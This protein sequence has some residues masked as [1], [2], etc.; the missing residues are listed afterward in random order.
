MGRGQRIKVL[1]SV[2][3]LDGHSTGAEVVSR[4]L[5]DSGMEVVYLG[6]YQTPE[7]VV[8]AAIQEDV[9][10]IGISSHASNYGQI[11]ELMGLLREK[12]LEDICVICGGTIPKKQIKELKEK[13]VSEVFAPQ[14]T[15][16]AIVNYII[17]NAKRYK[18]SS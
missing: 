10:V 16:E 12:K 6:I 8:Q 7:M 17:S 11:V 14:S 5:M 13:G 15:S 18:V 2:I 9:D 3:G 4:M 1:V